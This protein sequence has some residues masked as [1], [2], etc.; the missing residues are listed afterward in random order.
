MRRK[1]LVVDDAPIVRTGTA[2]S[3]TDMGF[4]VDQAQS[5]MEALGL[6]KDTRYAIILMDYHMPEMDGTE[7]TRL[8]RSY[9]S[10][11]GTR[12]PIVCLT[13]DDLSEV[14]QDC[15]NAG[16]DACLSKTC[17]IEELEKMIVTW[18]FNASNLISG[19]SNHSQGTYP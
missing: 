7:C 3:L 5:G 11:T 18:K 12:T 9:E 10:E 19:Q 2:M 8:I 17:S 14:C 13:S 4:E 1:I 15:L 16:M 6:V